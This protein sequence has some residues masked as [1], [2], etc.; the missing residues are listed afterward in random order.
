MEYKGFSISV[1][2]WIYSLKRVPFNEKKKRRER[3]HRTKWMDTS[4]KP[5]ATICQDLKTFAFEMNSSRV[6]S[7]LRNEF[8]TCTF[9]L[10]PSPSSK[11]N[12]FGVFRQNDVDCQWRVTASKQF[13]FADAK[14]KDGIAAIG[15]SLQRIWSYRTS[16]SERR[17]GDY[18]IK[19]ESGNDV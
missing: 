17:R 6:W 10:I 5:V 9:D 2:V 3:E 13:H 14:W 4:A 16:V 15:K 8:W 19:P 1:S 7:N 12:R 11:T 18:V